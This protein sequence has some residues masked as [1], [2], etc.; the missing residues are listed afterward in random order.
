[1]TWTPS[2]LAASGCRLGTLPYAARRISS[3]GTRALVLLAG[4]SGGGRATPPAGRGGGRGGGGGGERGDDAFRPARDWLERNPIALKS[5]SMGI[6]YAFADLTAQLYSR[7]VDPHERMPW[8]ERARRACGLGLIGLFVVGPLL[9][10]WFDWLEVVFPGRGALAI[11]ART[12]CDQVFEVPVII[13]LI[14]VLSSLAEGHD[15]GFAAEKVRHKLV[16]TWKGC[17]GVWLPVQLVNQGLVPLGYRVYFQSA[18]SFFWDTY[19][20]VAAHAPIGDATHAAK[21]V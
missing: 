10:L 3:R 21:A 5:L 18:V 6:T 8:A 9:T 16:P 1:L 4:G 17:V 20:S 12:L 7:A 2:A 15:L 11:A 13:S 19:M 14:F